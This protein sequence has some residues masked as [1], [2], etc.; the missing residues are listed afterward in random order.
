MSSVFR[1]C[2]G[3]STGFNQSLCQ[4]LSFF[5]CVEQ[6]YRLERREA[7]AGSVGITGAGFVD[8]EL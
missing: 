5:R 3:N 8:Y 4:F 7:M 6:C 2:F 1:C